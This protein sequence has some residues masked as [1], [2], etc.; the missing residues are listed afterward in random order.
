MIV[1][2]SAQQVLQLIIMNYITIIFIFILIFNYLVYKISENSD[3][4]HS[5]VRTVQPKDIQ[6]TIISNRQKQLNITSERLESEIFLA[7]SLEKSLNRLS[8]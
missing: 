5:F 6:I 7:F 4:C 1:S 2:E 3:K 8:K